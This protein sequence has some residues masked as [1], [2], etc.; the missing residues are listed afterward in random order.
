MIADG[1]WRIMMI[2]LCTFFGAAALPVFGAITL[3]FDENYRF[4][5]GYYF[6][7]AL[8]LVIFMLCV[9][10]VLTFTLLH[11]YAPEYMHG[12]QTL[13]LISCI[14]T[15]SLGIAL[16]LISL[17]VS[18]ELYE[19][20]HRI[21]HGCMNSNTD[22]SFLMDYDQ[23]LYNIKMQPGCRGQE[24]VQDCP[25]W[26]SNRYTR[27]I[28]YLENEFQCGPVC[29]EVPIPKVQTL[30]Q[31]P[32]HSP[33]PA[34]APGPAV[35][36]GDGGDGGGSASFLQDMTGLHHHHH[37][38]GGHHKTTSLLQA[39][40]RVQA[41]QVSGEVQSGSAWLAN[42]PQVRAT[43]LFSSGTTR[44]SCYTIVSTRLQV[45][46][47]CFGDL[48]FWE[49]IGLMIVSLALSFFAFVEQCLHGKPNVVS[50]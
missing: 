12:E 34:P 49:G 41:V 9:G 16:V 25:G 18:R 32:M 8:L 43:K 19:V 36:G 39:E 47:W 15:A 46:A 27:Y 35:V 6:P 22:S 37:H 7:F 33:V 31:A 11:K 14:F 42:P 45:L 26:Q 10:L 48:M 5:V 4:W 20:G 28:E 44:T 17:P 30:F 23:V 2:A 21:G 1:E 38:H 24:S 40:D 3:L 29:P 50:H 13:A